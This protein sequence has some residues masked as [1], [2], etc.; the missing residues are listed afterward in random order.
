MDPDMGISSIPGL[1]ITMALTGKK[2]FHISPCLTTFTF[3]DLPL[4]TVHEQTILLFSSTPHHGFFSPPRAASHGGIVCVRLCPPS[5][6]VSVS[7]MFLSL[8]QS[9]PFC[10]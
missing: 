1:N 4:S 3:P 7:L 5:P 10:V 8:S 9:P 2:A 6:N